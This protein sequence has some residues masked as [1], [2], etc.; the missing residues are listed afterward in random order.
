MYSVTWHVDLPNGTT[1]S[2][3]PAVAS[4][5]DRL[6][7]EDV[8]ASAL[9]AAKVDGGESPARLARRV[10]IF[11]RSAKP[12][13][14]NAHISVSFDDRNANRSRTGSRAIVDDLDATLTSQ[15]VMHFVRPAPLFGMNSRESDESPYVGV[16][17]VV[18]LLVPAIALWMLWKPFSRIVARAAMSEAIWTQGPR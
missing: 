17:V 13:S 8:V 3:N 2:N 12:N 6:I 15:R 1:R 11:F 4:A 16:G 18:G 5:L 14:P 7:D 9:R 10:F